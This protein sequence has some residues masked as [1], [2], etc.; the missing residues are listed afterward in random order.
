[1]EGVIDW[2]DQRRLLF[3]ALAIVV[4]STGVVLQRAGQYGVA[5]HVT[6]ATVPILLALVVFVRA[7]RSSKRV[8]GSIVCALLVLSAALDLVIE[9]ANHPEVTAFVLVTTVLMFGASIPMGLFTVPNSRLPN[10]SALPAE[11]RDVR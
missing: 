11:Q 7:R 1:M 2:I 4:G 6:S 5:T 8:L 10:Q 3:W 9:P